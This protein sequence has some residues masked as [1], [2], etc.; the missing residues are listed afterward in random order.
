MQV[1]ATR[2]GKP[3]PSKDC[4]NRLSFDIPTV[5]QHVLTIC[6]GRSSPLF[7]ATPGDILH[8]TGRSGP[9]GITYQ[10]DDLRLEKVT[11]SSG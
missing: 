9:F 7:E 5:S 6:A 11:P 1:T 8:L 4:P 3:S 2:I 10:R